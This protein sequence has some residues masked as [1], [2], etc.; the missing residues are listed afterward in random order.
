M[1]VLLAHRLRHATMGCLFVFLT[2]RAQQSASLPKAAIDGTGPGWSVL[3]KEHFVNVNCDPDTWTWTNGLIRCT[4]KP[5]GVIRSKKL[6]TNFELVAQW[7]HLQ[8]GG[9][10]GIFVWAAPESIRVL[11]KGKERLPA[12]IEVQILDHGY[13]EQYEKQY[14]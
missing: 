3:N 8:P 4:G 12:G 7:R 9:N 6:Y 14:K 5:T 2:V 13:T 10:S 11:E 1:N